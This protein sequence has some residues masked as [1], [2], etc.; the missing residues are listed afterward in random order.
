MLGWVPALS[1][2]RDGHLGHVPHYTTTSAV[3]KWAN[4]ELAEDSMNQQAEKRSFK[5]PV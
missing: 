5:R 4:I 2:D 1:T 3:C